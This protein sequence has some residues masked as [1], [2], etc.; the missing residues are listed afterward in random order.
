MSGAR[1][2]AGVRATATEQFELNMRPYRASDLD[3]CRQLAG[4]S[5]DFAHAVDESAD[6]FIVAEHRGEI[7]G[8]AFLQVW[9]WNRVAWLGEIIVD[10]KWRGHGVGTRLLQRMEAEARKLGCRAVMDHP[11]PSHPSV[12]FYL[13]HGYRICGYND[14]FFDDPGAATALFVQKNI[15]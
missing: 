6:S 2:R 11:P 10:P 13:K 4:R 1:K 15:D 14:A 7:V 8:L 5:A 3:A 12:A 9:Q